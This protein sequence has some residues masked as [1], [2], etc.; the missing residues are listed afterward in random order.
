[1]AA[2]TQHVEQEIRGV[3]TLTTA[4]LTTI[5]ELEDERNYYVMNFDGMRSSERMASLENILSD[6]LIFMHGY[7]FNDWLKKQKI[8]G[9]DFYYV[10]DTLN[11]TDGDIDLI[12][13]GYEIAFTIWKQFLKKLG[14]GLPTEFFRPSEKDAGFSI[15]SS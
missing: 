12:R 13:E 6:M 7:K 9:Y 15:Q 10:K 1:M 14:V 11:D 3:Y 5:N 2:E 8:R 4:D